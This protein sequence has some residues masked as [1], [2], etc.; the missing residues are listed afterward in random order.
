[1]SQQKSFHPCIDLHVN[2][3][4]LL[5]LV[6]EKDNLVESLEEVHVVVAILLDLVEQSHLGA[7]VAGEASEQRN[8]LL[9]VA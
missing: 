6:K 9:Q 2:I 7:G 3:S 5:T 8:M 1:M 4:A